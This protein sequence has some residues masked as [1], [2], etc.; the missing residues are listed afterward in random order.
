MPR[1]I[2]AT[3][4]ATQLEGYLYYF[5]PATSTHPRR[6]EH[7]FTLLPGHTWEGILED[8]NAGLM[9]IDPADPLI[10]FRLTCF[11]ANTVEKHMLSGMSLAD[12]CKRMMDQVPPYR[13]LCE[14]PSMRL[15]MVN[16]L[17]AYWLHGEAFVEWATV[18]TW[19]LQMGLTDQRVKS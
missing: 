19:W 8:M 14:S 13:D 10:S 7:R 9:Q 1:Q 12:A 18:T 2:F 11:F 6:L 5:Y 15:A 16:F 3:G 17:A 4:G